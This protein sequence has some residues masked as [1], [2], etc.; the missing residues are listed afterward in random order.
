MKT[1]KR[2]FE[3]LLK[4]SPKC[5]AALA[6]LAVVIGASVT[7]AQGVNF[8]GIFANT[9]GVILAPTNIF[10]ANIAPLTNALN[11]A[12]YSSGGGG[13]NSASG[14]TSSGT[15]IYPSGTV[16]TGGGW[17]STSTIIYPQ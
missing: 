2:I 10:S 11:A 1:I 7:L 12:G 14:W 9:N 16:V 3:N 6:A 15:T 5:L 4:K 8:I 13:T 17:V